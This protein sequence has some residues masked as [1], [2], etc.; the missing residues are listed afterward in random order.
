MRRM[1]DPDIVRLF[2]TSAQRKRR[3]REILERE[4]GEDWEQSEELE[5]L[6]FDSDE[7]PGIRFMRRR[8]G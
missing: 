4:Y 7:L 6:I 2:E 3:E 1:C 5:A 8:N